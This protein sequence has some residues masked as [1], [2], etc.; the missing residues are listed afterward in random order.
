MEREA[1][2]GTTSLLLAIRFVLGWSLWNGEPRRICVRS[3]APT[4]RG[5]LLGRHVCQQ[6][7]VTGQSDWRRS[8]LTTAQQGR[9]ASRQRSTRHPRAPTQDKSRSANHFGKDQRRQL[10]PRPTLFRCQLRAKERRK[11][12]RYFVTLARRSRNKEK[13]NMYVCGQHFTRFCSPRGRSLVIPAPFYEIPMD[14][15]HDARRS[16]PYCSIEHACR[17]RTDV[18]GWAGWYMCLLARF[19][20]ANAHIGWCFTWPS[21]FAKCGAQKRKA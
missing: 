4:P 12:T 20:R 15:A 17:F 7:C 19:P 11:E 6:C 2:S 14:D 21:L 18:A 8:W 10:A 1:S 5:R 13:G 9:T 3:P 16:I